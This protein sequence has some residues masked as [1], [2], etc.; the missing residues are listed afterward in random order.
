MQG[1]WYPIFFSFVGGVASLAGGVGLLIWR[2]KLMKYTSQMTSFA[3]G[4]MLTVAIVDL[5]P[6]AAANG[7]MKSLSFWLLFGIIFLFLLEKTSI[8]FHH[9]HEPHGHSPNIVGVWI[10]DTLHNFT[11]GLAIGASF[12]FGREMGIVTA[13]AVGAHELPHE[14]ADFS[15]YVKAGMSRTKTLALNLISSLAT[16]IGAIAIY[17]VGQTLSG[18]AGKVMALA[19]GM[20]LYVALADL[21]PELHQDTNKKAIIWQLAFFIGGIVLMYL[22]LASLG[23]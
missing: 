7:E 19:A 16:V 17:I 1:I 23:V 21:V 6:E 10:G 15:I 4:V 20:F 9:H 8:W 11:D 14:M 3:A 22:T 18:L 13:I 2:D 5:I 12:L